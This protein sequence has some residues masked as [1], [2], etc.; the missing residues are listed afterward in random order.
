MTASWERRLRELRSRVL[1]RAWDYRQ[2]R[3][4]RG[5]WFRLRRTLAGASEAHAV[6]AAEA[7]QLVAEGYPLEPVGSELAPSKLI[8]IV[9]AARL[10]RISSA[11]P[12]IVTLNADLLAA[13]NLALVPFA[14]ATRDGPP[15]APAP[16]ESPHGQV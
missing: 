10:R 8:V 11:R 13:E 15:T 9:P 7:R 1:S 12:L 2:R 4:A 3:H 6:S 16:D 14:A 5:A